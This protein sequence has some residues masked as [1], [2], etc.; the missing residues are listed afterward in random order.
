MTTYAIISPAQSDEG[1]EALA[2]AV[3]V[4][5]E[6]DRIELADGVWLIRSSL[7]TGVQ[8]KAF[9]GINVGAHSGIVLTVVDQTG[10]ASHDLATRLQAWQF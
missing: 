1:K 5:D 10:V 7:A 9:L 6:N 3:R 4:I 8:L 2:T